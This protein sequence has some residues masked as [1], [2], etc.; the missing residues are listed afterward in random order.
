MT[1]KPGYGKSK[2]SGFEREICKKLSL[3][4]SDG[5]RDDC[6]WR[7]AMSGGRAS[8]QFKKGKDNKSQVGDISPITALGEKLLDKF[9]VECKAYRNIRIDSLIYGTPKHDS[10]L[11]FWLQLVKVCDEANKHPMLIFKENGKNTILGV[12]SYFR[13]NIS[14]SNY[15]LDELAFFEQHDLSLYYLDIALGFIDPAIL[16]II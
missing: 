9:V 11:E 15:Q 6:F 8:V 1:T 13:E 16:E 10:L 5:E 12:D 4:I 14:G 2:G 7:S 3:W